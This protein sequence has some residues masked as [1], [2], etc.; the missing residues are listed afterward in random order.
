MPT[1]ILPHGKIYL[2]IFVLINIV[3]AGS[4]LCTRERK[5]TS[6]SA[7]TTTT[8][9][10]TRTV[11]LDLVL[12]SK[13]SVALRDTA[14]FPRNVSILPRPTLVLLDSLPTPPVTSTLTTSQGTPKTTPTQIIEIPENNECGPTNGIPTLD[15]TIDGVPLLTV[16]RLMEITVVRPGPLAQASAPTPAELRSLATTINTIASQPSVQASTMPL[17]VISNGAGSAAPL[18]TQANLLGSI[19]AAGSP[20]AAPSLSPASGPLGS[21]DQGAPV[22]VMDSPLQPESGN[23]EDPGLGVNSAVFEKQSAQ[24]SPGQAQ[25]SEGLANPVPKAMP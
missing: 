19:K 16:T 21:P 2:A 23:S 14:V 24:H 6:A 15:R 20:Q 12:P 4:G 13:S 17:A 18:E 8:V 11:Y 22:D 9:T 5:I 1:S 25:A 7:R 3:S 10:L